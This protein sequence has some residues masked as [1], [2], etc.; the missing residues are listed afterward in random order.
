M[1]LARREDP[2]APSARAAV[3]SREVREARD[4]RDAR[5]VR[6][7]R[8]QGTVELAMVLPLVALLVLVTIQVALVARD[9]V[10][11]V[12]AA[13]EGAR[14]AAV[15]ESA[16]QRA[17]AA[18]RA[19]ERSGSFAAGTAEVRTAVADGGRR[20]EVTVRHRNP[21]DLPLV[22]ALVPDVVVSSRTVM[23]IE[24]PEGS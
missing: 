20:V 19:V 4:A 9:H 13:R 15:A 11:V 17:A 12:H 16:G 23:R 10:L 7:D 8:G 2:L 14:A 1:S 21:T 18:D 5:Q 24:Q 6:G 22:G 3:P